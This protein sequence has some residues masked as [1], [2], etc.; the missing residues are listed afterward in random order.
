M[1]TDDFFSKLDQ[2]IGDMKKA[3][4]Q[5]SEKADD[6]AEFVKKTVLRLKKVAEEYAGE[7]RGRDIQVDV[8]VSVFELTFAPRY[9]EPIDSAG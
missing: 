5:F 8:G 4:Q 7:L 3:E 6:D 1:S 9:K 2:K